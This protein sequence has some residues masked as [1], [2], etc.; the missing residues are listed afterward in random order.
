LEVLVSGMQSGIK[1]FINSDTTLERFVNQYAMTKYQFREWGKFLCQENE[2]GF[3]N[4]RLEHFYGP[5]D[6]PSKFTTHVIQSCSSQTKELLLT[7][8]DQLRDFVYIDDVVSGFG[9]ILN[10]IDLFC[11]GFYQFDLGSGKAISI[12]EF[13]ILVKR[14]TASNTTLRFGSIPYRSNEP[15][16]SEADTSKMEKLGWSRKFSL[17]DGLKLTIDRGLF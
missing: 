15:M 2:F 5:G 12:R 3:V 1:T 8:G 6:D 10:N 13:A 7:K 14:L 11:N 9:S 4:L 16:F 17:E